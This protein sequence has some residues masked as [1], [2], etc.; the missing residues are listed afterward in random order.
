MA[1]G[2]PTTTLPNPLANQ[3]NPY[4]TKRTSE[5]FTSPN[6]NTPSTESIIKTRWK[7]LRDSYRKIIKN[8]PDDSDRCN[9]KWRYYKAMGFMKMITMHTTPRSSDITKTEEVPIEPDC[10]LKLEMQDDSLFQGVSGKESLAI[11]R[12]AAEDLVSHFLEL[13]PDDDSVNGLGAEEDYHFLRAKRMAEEYH[14]K[15]AENAEYHF[16]AGSYVDESRGK[17]A[18]NDEDYQFLMSLHPYLSQVAQNR[19]LP[20]RMKIEQ[21]IYDEVYE[22]AKEKSPECNGNT[23]Q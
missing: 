8:N 19:K 14:A 9:A 23:A 10:T 13:Q 16:R 11:K 21:L 1:T 3:A 2:L 15:D 6:K 12:E 18:P 7:N 20:L 22:Q 5:P 4:L 17:K